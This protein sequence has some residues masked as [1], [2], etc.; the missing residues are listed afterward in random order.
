MSKPV[1]GCPWHGPVQSNW[2]TLPTGQTKAWPQPAGLQT[3]APGSTPLYDRAGETHRLALLG[4]APVVRSVEEQAVDMAKG[5]QW[6]TEAILSGAQ[7]QL[8]GTPL[9]GWIYLDPA[10]DRWLVTCA[11]LHEAN[12]YTIGPRSFDITL[13]R[14]GDIGQAAEQHVYSVSLTDWGLDAG[15]LPDK[16]RLLVDAIHPAGASA[17]IMVHE[18]RPTQQ[19]IR[20]PHSFLQLSISGAG[21]DATLAFSVAR[22]RSQVHTFERTNPA[23]AYYISAWRRLYGPGGVGI[24]TTFVNVPF[25]KGSQAQGGNEYLLDYEKF[26]PQGYPEERWRGKTSYVV[27]GQFEF[28]SRRILALWYGE[29]GTLKEVAVKHDVQTTENSPQPEDGYRVATA[30]S[31]WT[32]KLEVGGLVMAEISGSDSITVTELFANQFYTGPGSGEVWPWPSSRSQQYSQTH[33]G[34]TLAYTT[35]ETGDTW[36]NYFIQPFGATAGL[37]NEWQTFR[38]DAVEGLQAIGL[39]DEQVVDVMFENGFPTRAPVSFVRYANHVIGMR[40]QRTT[41][42][43]TTYAYHPPVTPSGVASG[44]VFV[45]ASTITGRYGSWCPFTHA[46]RWR[47]ASPFCYV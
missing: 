10:G 5:W 3:P 23:G 42:A 19:Q 29:D 13:S 25:I 39:A 32:V 21:A 22:S 14:F 31:T 1:W 45:G 27:S 28:I 18:R 9:N 38:Q 40:A 43:S 2:L 24:S 44:E 30:S 47:L 46:S 12:E 7:Q 15:T 8:Y 34:A 6:R 20:W 16:A 26:S 35:E 17:I 11:A 4:V 33:D 36:F 37:G 41:D